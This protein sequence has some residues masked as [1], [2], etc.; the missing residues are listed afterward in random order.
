MAGVTL[1]AIG[2]PMDVIA[3]V[4]AATLRGELVARVY[5]R[6]VTGFAAQPLVFAG[7]GKI[8]LPV[9]IE[10]PLRPGDRVVTAFA[11][12]AERLLVRIFLVTLMTALWRATEMRIGMTRFAANRRVCSQ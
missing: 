5:F 6:A 4:A 1:R 12:L 11:L 9:M 8:G 2:T 10:L 3:D 7:Q